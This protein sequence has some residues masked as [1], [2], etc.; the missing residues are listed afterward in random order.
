MPDGADHGVYSFSSSV[1]AYALF[2]LVRRLPAAVAGACSAMR[3]S[4]PVGRPP[5]WLSFRLVLKQQDA[6]RRADGTGMFARQPE[7]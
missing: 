3:P 2:W 4:Y 5:R 7:V 6:L 1:I